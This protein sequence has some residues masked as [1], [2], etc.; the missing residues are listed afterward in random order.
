MPELKPMAICNCDAPGESQAC[1]GCVNLKQIEERKRQEKLKAI[2]ERL[3]L[4]EIL[5]ARDKL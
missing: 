5:L 4:Q 3:Q 2:S 1:K